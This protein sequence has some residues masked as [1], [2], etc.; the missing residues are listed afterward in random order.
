LIE[1]SQKSRANDRKLLLTSAVVNNDI[2][3]SSKKVSWN[4]TTNQPPD[5]FDS[6]IIDFAIIHRPFV[7]IEG[8]ANGLYSINC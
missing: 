2:A 7:G 8:T 3:Y 4:T 6:E 1:I 5:G